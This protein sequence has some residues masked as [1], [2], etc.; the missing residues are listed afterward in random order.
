MTTPG[1]GPRLVSVKDV[2]AT[3]GV[4]LGTVSNV[5][6]RPHRVTTQTR[7]RVQRAM[8]D[9]GFVRNESARRLRTGVSHTMAF[10]MLDA[11]NPFFTDVA[12][13]IEL[14]V[15]HEGLS[16]ML[17]NSRNIA[18]RELAHLTQLEQ[19]RVQGILI[20]PLDPE[21]PTLEELAGR[22]TP[23]VIVDRHHA[24]GRFCS[25]AVDDVLGG[26]LAIEH[27]IDRGHH[28]VAFVGG[29]RAVGQ[30]AA[31]WQGAQEAWASASLTRQRLTQL[32]TVDL[33]PADG[34][35]AG[36]RLAGITAHRRPTAV[37]CANDMIAL[38]V[39]QHAVNSGIPVPEEL[40]IVGYDDIDF[41]AA[42]A[43]PLSSV[44][45]PRHILG[46]AAADLVLDEAANPEHRHRQLLYVPELIARASTV[47]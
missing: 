25:V 6:N 19:Q 47:G 34:R 27:L 39:L 9:L 40:A 35:E 8:T 4:S 38:G 3:A 16:L 2:A 43:V 28:S 21:S 33:T 24:D 31:R 41:A 37:F 26:R 1:R 11:S 23:V 36:Q 5:L 32:T 30:V 22:G 12:S 7:E 15:E 17:C 14:S 20:T 44:R 42:A 45:R 29:S 13:G 10:V 18:A 46:R